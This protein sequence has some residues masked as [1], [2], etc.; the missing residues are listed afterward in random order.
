MHRWARSDGQKPDKGVEK[1]QKVEGW[2][3]EEVAGYRSKWD[4]RGGEQG[5]GGSM[6]YKDG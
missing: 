5:E 4:G 3:E 2:S 6:R 1:I